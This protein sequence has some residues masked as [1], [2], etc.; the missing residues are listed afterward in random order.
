MS[1]TIV[2]GRLER[3]PVKPPVNPH[4]SVRLMA[5]VAAAAGLWIFL[6]LI[7]FRGL[8]SVWA[9]APLLFALHAL[10]MWI[11]RYGLPWR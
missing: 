9:Q 8:G 10:I 11:T 1:A 4:V 7:D 2:Q 5:G 3:F 6:A